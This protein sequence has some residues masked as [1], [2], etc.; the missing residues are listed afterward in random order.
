MPS[1]LTLLLTILTTSFLSACQWQTIG[2][3]QSPNTPTTSGTKESANTTNSHQTQHRQSDGEQPPASHQPGDVPALFKRY[4]A[5]RLEQNPILA[6]QLGEPVRSAWPDL[7]VGTH[8][9]QQR[10]LNTFSAELN[11]IDITTLD[12]KNSLYIRALNLYVQRQQSELD[13]Q[14]V[15]PPF[16]AK[17][18]WHK[19]VINTLKYHQP[20]AQIS[21]FYSYLRRLRASALLFNNWQANIDRSTAAGILPPTAHREI[22]AA[23]LSQ[24]LEGYPFSDS[25]HANILWTDV[26]EKIHALMLYPK[27]QAFLE[28]QAKEVFINHL[29]PSLRQ[30]KAAVAYSATRGA[31]TPS[32][33]IQRKQTACYEEQ[34]VSL[35]ASMLTP[36][37]AIDPT[38]APDSSQQPNEKTAT[39]GTPPVVAQTLIERAHYHALTR[40]AELEQQLTELLQFDAGE[41]FAPQLRAWVAG[42]KPHADN[43]LE[44]SLKR[45]QQLNQRL[46][47]QFARLPSTPLVITSTSSAQTPNGSVD[48][49][50]GYYPPITA[51]NWPAFYYAQTRSHSHQSDSASTRISENRGEYWPSAL[52]QQT[53]PGKHVQMA[54]PMENPS[55][56]LF[57]S[58][59]G[60]RYPST[61]WPLLASEL[62]ARMGGYISNA[63]QAGVLISELEAQLDLVLDTATHGLNWTQDKRHAVCMTHSTMDTRGCNDTLRQIHINPAAAGATSLSLAQLRQLIDNARQGSEQP[64]F[65]QVFYSDLL[66]QGGLPPE[67]YPAW[68][69]TWQH[70]D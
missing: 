30:L 70:R 9:R 34:L 17:H 19:Q 15:L 48:H 58:T 18:A 65:S 28:K 59:P 13:C 54:L 57:L 20:I 32:Q 27:S 4:R 62:S 56:P 52:Y 51:L 1:R 29:L 41:A 50:S 40:I 12:E 38:I 42:H 7:T 39:A 63:E 25:G 35:G 22:V 43:L 46:P 53:L 47:E 68:L 14:N 24:L 8:K 61:G 66:S 6:S 67:L 31:A 45:I 16:G 2:Q 26:Q 21:D 36:V 11:E 10:W 64:F 33:T 5:W 44:D 55:L 3:W 69:E 60:I 37:P 23:E 49:A